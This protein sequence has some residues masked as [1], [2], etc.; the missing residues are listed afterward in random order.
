[1]RWALQYNTKQYKSYTTVIVGYLLFL[2]LF[3]FIGE[4]DTI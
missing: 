4:N 1:M 2:L 3:Y